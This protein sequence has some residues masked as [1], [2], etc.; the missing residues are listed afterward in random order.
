MPSP[1]CALR[2]LAFSPVPS[3]TTVE[4][5][6]ST[7]TQQSVNDPPW[8]NTGVNVVPRLIVFQSP[9]NA[10]ATYQ[11]LGFFG[12]MAM[13]CTR[14]VEM[15]GPMLRSSRPLRASAVSPPEGTGA[16]SFD[17][18]RSLR[19]G[20]APM[21]AAAATRR[22]ATAA[23]SLDFILMSCTLSTVGTLRT[24]STSGFC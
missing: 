19:T 2:W 22:A 20:R 24:I 15:A 16:C 11:V 13:S 21:A 18:L 7:T 5:F 1:K 4:L 6:G 3:Q 23:T 17:S 10:V 8:S 9:P 12:S 14:P